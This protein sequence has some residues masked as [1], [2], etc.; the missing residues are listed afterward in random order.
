MK[1]GN[2]LTTHPREGPV[3]FFLIDIDAVRMLRGPLGESRRVR[4][5]A[6]LLDLPARLDAEA[7]PG[8]LAG[9]ARGD[10]SLRERLGR[11]ASLALEERRRERQERTGARYVDEEVADA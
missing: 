4:N 7:A 5:L 11:L 2:M 1:A 10:E 8:L 3:R 9:Y 6:Q